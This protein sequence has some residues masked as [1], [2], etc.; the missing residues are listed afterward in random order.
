MGRHRRA[1]QTIEDGDIVG[2]GR[3]TQVIERQLFKPLKAKRR[4]DFVIGELELLGGERQRVL[5]PSENV[6]ATRAALADERPGD[7]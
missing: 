5:E 3:A 6:D 2:F 1:R 7:L 4:R